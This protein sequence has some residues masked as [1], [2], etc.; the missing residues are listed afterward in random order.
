M[1]WLR[2]KPLIRARPSEISQ[3]TKDLQ[4]SEIRRDFKYSRRSFYSLVLRRLM[5]L[6]F[7]ELV[8][9]RSPFYKPVWQPIP[10]RAP[11][12]H[13]WWNLSYL[14]AKSWNEYFWNDE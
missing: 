10:K 8:Q 1:C 14:I 4:S 5:D 7:I 11:G 12:G 3:F 9:H 6:G 13:N 2:N